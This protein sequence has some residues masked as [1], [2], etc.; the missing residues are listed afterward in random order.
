ML[1]VVSYHA[2]KQG[3]FSLCEESSSCSGQGQMLM[4]RGAKIKGQVPTGIEA[5]NWEAVAV[6]PCVQEGRVGGGC[7]EVGKLI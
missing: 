5:V 6:Q 7:K 2:K 4:V 1:S 3:A